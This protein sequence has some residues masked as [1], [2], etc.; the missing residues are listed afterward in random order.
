MKPIKR[1]IQIL[2]VVA[3]LTG[4]YAVLEYTRITQI[5]PQLKTYTFNGQ[6]IHYSNA[7]IRYHL[8]GGLISFDRTYTEDQ[9]TTVTTYQIL[10][11]FS[12]DE[13]TR[14]TIT[15]PDQQIQTLIG[16][17]ELAFEADGE[18]KIEL[19]DS[20]SQGNLTHYAFF[21]VVDSVAQITLSNLNPYQGELLVIDLANIQRDSTIAIES[22]FLASVVTQ[23]DHTARFYLPI[24]YR[25]P[26]K[27]YP[28]SVVINDKK[29]DF[30]L[31]VKP[32]DFNKIYFTVSDDI[33]NSPAGSPEASAQFRKATTPLYDLVEPE[34]LHTGAFILPVNDARVSS[35][36]GDMRYIN[37]AT[38]P[39]RHGGIDYAIT[40]GTPVL[41]SNSGKVQ[42]ADFLDLTGNTV[43]I[44]HGLGLK[45]VYYHMLDLTIEAGDMVEKG[46]L[47]GHVG[48][49]GYST[50]CHLHFQAMIK[51][52]PINPDFLY[53]LFK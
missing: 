19:E 47:I 12:V 8:L 44:E 24:Q 21:V 10:H 5:V 53:Q 33:L 22:A 1:L 31:T 2:V 11:A 15:S 29:Y 7:V 40:C 34:E 50:G 17:Q 39:S 30:S 42:Y 52:Q 38:T 41:A 4:S 23:Q 48:T 9:P 32:F 14:I 46:Q 27:V 6:T 49:T 20:D 18:Y 37:G 45:T 16:P 25:D 35:E 51:N 3:V 43:Y 13:S 26:A 36:F 28:L